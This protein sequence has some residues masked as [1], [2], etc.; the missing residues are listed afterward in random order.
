MQNK[1]NVVRQTISPKEMTINLEYIVEGFRLVKILNTQESKA[2]ADLKI[3]LDGEQRL[4]SIFLPARHNKPEFLDMLPITYRF[5]ELSVFYEG[6]ISFG[7]CFATPSSKLK[8]AFKS[9]TINVL[10]SGVT[11]PQRQQK[12]S[13]SRKCKRTL[14][15]MHTYLVAHNKLSKASIIEFVFT[16]VMDYCVSFLFFGEG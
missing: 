7:T 4:Y 8:F 3:T 10:Q 14:M 6:E 16:L 9:D 15:M 2:V 11:L 5:E 12:S 1:F 13:A